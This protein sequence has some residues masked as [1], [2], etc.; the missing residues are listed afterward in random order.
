MKVRVRGTIAAKERTTTDQWQ[1]RINLFRDFTKKSLV[2]PVAGDKRTM[3][4][5]FTKSIGV[6]ENEDMNV[7]PTLKKLLRIYLEELK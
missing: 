2:L 7:R 1:D 4:N 3:A 6:I 5:Y